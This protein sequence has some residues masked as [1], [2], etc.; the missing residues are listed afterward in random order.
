MSRPRA[1][2]ASIAATILA[3]PALAG[4]S[5]QPDLEVC[6]QHLARSPGGAA[7]AL[8]VYEVATGKSP[9]RTTASRRLEEL[10]AKYPA[11]PWLLLYLGKLKRQT[12]RPDEV[13]EAAELYLLAAG[14]AGR[15]GMAAAEYEARSG[16]CRILRD[17]GRL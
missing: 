9:L 2:F 10:V 13:Q 1:T 7:P 8:C 4:A 12:H 15:R 6:E 11:D 14:I 5:P 17:A 16:L 3:I